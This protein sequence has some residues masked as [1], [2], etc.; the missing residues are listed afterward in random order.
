LGLEFRSTAAGSSHVQVEL[1]FATEG[2]LKNFSE[3]ELSLGK[4]TTL[5]VR[6]P[7]REDRSKPGRVVV[8]FTADRTQLDK[9]TLW[10]RTPYRDGSLGGMV[11]EL[12]VKD[13]VEVK[14]VP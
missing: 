2:P 5:A 7:L 12:P 9:L 6:A 3:V 8:N 13:F 1:E 10:V 11:F 14:K 4:G